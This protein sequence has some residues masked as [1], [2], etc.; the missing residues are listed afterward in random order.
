MR[1]G[2]ASAFALLLLLAQVPYA[3]ETFD[4]LSLSSRLAPSYGQSNI[5]YKTNLGICEL[6]IKDNPSD[7]A[8]VSYYTDDELK[9]RDRQAQLDRTSLGEHTVDMGEYR[10]SRYQPAQ[11]PGR[12]DLDLQYASVL[13]SCLIGMQAQL[14]QEYASQAEADAA[15]SAFPPSMASLGAQ[16]KSNSALA[17]FCVPEQQNVTQPPPEQNQTPPV[18]PP[19]AEEKCVVSDVAVAFEPMYSG[20]GMVDA[21]SPK[22]ASRLLSVVGCPAQLFFAL[23]T[24]CMSKP[25]FCHSRTC[26]SIGLQL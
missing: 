23:M 3:F 1:L 4:C 12:Q 2:I 7:L 13:G 26:A 18:Q 24:S 15:F 5:L 8:Y 9:E 11:Y 22:P 17:A 16:M 10:Y 14:F 25:S 21:V 6:D 20:F 19:P